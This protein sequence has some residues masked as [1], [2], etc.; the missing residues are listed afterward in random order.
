MHPKFETLSEDNEFI[1]LN[2]IVFNTNLIKDNITNS[3]HITNNSFNSCSKNKFLRKYFR[4]VNNQGIYNRIEW[5]FW[6]K[7]DIQCELITLNKIRPLNELQIKVILD[8]SSKENY[9]NQYIDLKVLLD[10]SLKKLEAEDTP[11]IE[12]IETMSFKNLYE[13]DTAYFPSFSSKEICV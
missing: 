11:T 13:Q 9:N 7:Q 8:F 6:L 3:F 1:I 4:E 10:F 12:D 5:K 2:D